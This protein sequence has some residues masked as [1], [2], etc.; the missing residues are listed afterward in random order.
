[1][2]PCLS[3]SNSLECAVR[4]LSLQQVTHAARSHA[5]AF[6]GDV[7]PMLLPAL[8][9]LSIM[10]MIMLRAWFKDRIDELEVEKEDEPGSGLST[11]DD[12]LPM[13]AK[14]AGVQSLKSLCH[15]GRG[16]H[17]MGA[18]LLHGPLLFDALNALLC[19]KQSPP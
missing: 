8:K 4:R 11:L 6:I 19:A 14:F 7:T 1:M 18:A 2:I 3:H 17:P 12:A 10:Q 13:M 9:V 16:P 15:D 5:G